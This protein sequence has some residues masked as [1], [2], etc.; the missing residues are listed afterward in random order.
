MS[1]GSV[2]VIGG[3]LAGI[4]AALDCARGGAEVTLVEARG[5]LGGAAYSFT[6]GALTVDNGQHVFL[7]CCTAYRELLEQLD[8][9][10]LVTLQPL[11]VPVLAPGGPVG[12]LR[13]TNLPAPL[14]LAGSLL[15]YPHL[16]L[17]ERLAVAWAMQ[18]LRAV[19]VDDRAND[20]IAFGAWLRR[21]RQS[22]RAIEAMWELIVRATVN[23]SVE[24]ASLAQAAQVFQIGLLQEAAAGDI[25][26][27]AVPLGEI[28][29]RAAGHAL[30]AAGVTVRLRST[31]RAVIPEAG[32][33]GD[34]FHVRTSDGLDAQVDAVVIALPPARA[35]ALAP[36]Q[37]GLDGE[38]AARLG[39]S[40]IINLHVVYD[41][42]VLAHPFAAG[43]GS[44]VQWVFDR[45]AGSGCAEG[46]YLAVSLSAADAELHASAEALR[47]RYTPA[48]A[49]LIPAA[50]SA[51][52]REFFVTREHAATFR[53]APGARAWR[54]PASTRL[55]GLVL[56]GSWTDTGWP[57][58]MEGAVRSGRDAARTVM[59][60]LAAPSQVSASAPIGV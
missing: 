6:R 27:A 59:A 46:Q 20:G 50:R 12:W 26:W 33:D 29:D 31:A 30:A 43:V 10:E 47:A 56:A 53:A 40:P 13:R 60:F 11:A 45:T 48:L 2:M 38:L 1:R 51:S 49:D 18:R 35:L 41:R 52:V 28:H 16:S 9:A 54:P 4:S 23:L 3:G 15:R 55:R 24:E 7:R 39:T 25:G 42:R 57:A 21:H 44:P 17:R 14:H 22:S 5:R 37:A 8:A 32:P 58:T 19:D 34:R 36:P